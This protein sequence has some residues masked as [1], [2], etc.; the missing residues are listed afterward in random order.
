MGGSRSLPVTRRLLRTGLRWLVAG[1]SA[2]LTARLSQVAA[3]VRE[4]HVETRLLG[5]ASSG[6][7]VCGSAAAAVREVGVALPLQ[8]GLGD[9]EHASV[10]AAAS[11]TR[12]PGAWGWVWLSRT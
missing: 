9:Q 2:R 3:E 5:L 10:R 8:V 1:G 6:P 11:P 12:R 4:G 7:P